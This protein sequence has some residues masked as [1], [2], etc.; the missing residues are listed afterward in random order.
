MSFSRL[1]FKNRTKQPYGFLYGMRMTVG[2]FVGARCRGLMVTF[3]EL[4]GRAETQVEI[5][6][7]GGKH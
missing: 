4:T 2:G 7:E 6:R 1:S 5:F 3:Q